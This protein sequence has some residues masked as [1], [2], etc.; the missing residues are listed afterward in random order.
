MRE[1]IEALLIEECRLLDERRWDEWLDLFSDD[2]VYWWPAN[3]DDVD[4]EREVS[5]VYDDRAR[6]AERI[7]R[8]KS[9][10]AFAQDP[11]SRT[12]HL[13]GNLEVAGDESQVE[14]RSG[15]LLLEARTGRQAIY[16]GSCLHRLRREAD[17]WRIVL[18][19]VRLLGNDLPAGNL[20]FLI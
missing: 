7:W 4:P 18:K 17:G 10:N 5:L 11:P 9:G 19:K 6:L 2:A 8:L 1:R 20:T 13:I 16:G 3:R 15:F 14:A 12:Q